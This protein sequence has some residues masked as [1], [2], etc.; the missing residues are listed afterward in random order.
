MAIYEDSEVDREENGK[1]ESQQSNEAGK[2]KRDR[3]L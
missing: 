2:Q 1:I 3:K